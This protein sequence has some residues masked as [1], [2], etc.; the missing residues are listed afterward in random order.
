M[1]KHSYPTIA[2]NFDSDI[3]AIFSESHFWD[4]LHVDEFTTPN[5][6]IGICHQREVL[7]LIRERVMILV[8]AYND[9]VEDLASIPDLYLDYFK[10]VEKKMYPGFTKLMWS[11]RQIVIERFVQ[12]SNT[13]INANIFKYQ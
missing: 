3:V 1:R 4:K 9:L 13:L 2:S 10:L 12:V 8:R 5:V 6:I 11:T 7:R